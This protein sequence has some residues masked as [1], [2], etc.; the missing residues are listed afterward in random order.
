MAEPTSTHSFFRS[1]FARQQGFNRRRSTR[2]DL[3]IPI[4]LSARDARG[5][6]FRELTQTVTVNLHGARVR[7][8]REILVGMQVALENPQTG[9]LEKAV[10]VRVYESV[11]G[12][13]A[14]DVA[15]QLVR[16]GNIWGIENPPQD[17][18]TVAAN[19]LGGEASAQRPSAAGSPV[20]EPAIPIVESQVVSLEQQAATLTD[21]V[22]Q[23]FRQQ[24]QALANA[25]LQ[26]FRARLATIE[27]EAANRMNERGKEEL[28]GVTSVIDAMREDAAA[29]MATNAAEV[30]SE[31]EK[32]IRAKV[33]E[34][35]A[36]L[37]ELGVDITP[38]KPS[39]TY[40]RK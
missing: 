32:Q 6:A 26:D 5:E 9:A 18:L 29:Q 33:T 39:I 35:L 8:A 10:C 3:A 27:E 40:S 21:T 4:I 1:P 17:W 2:L 16:P 38:D 11:P 14:H 36:P 37:G 12:Q 23:T 13:V 30:I 15:V 34:I 25:V 28:A 24:I 19:L 22:L 20:G 31:A 7:T